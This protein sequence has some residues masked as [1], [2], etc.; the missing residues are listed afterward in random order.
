[1]EVTKVS[2][3]MKFEDCAF[4]RW[5]TDW[6]NERQQFLLF[7]IETSKMEHFSKK[8][9]RYEFSSKYFQNNFEFLKNNG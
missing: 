8:Y 5:N 2:L 6:P 4:L 9:D 7:E 1:M 3:G